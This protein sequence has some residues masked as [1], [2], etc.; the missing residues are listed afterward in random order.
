MTELA[1]VVGVSP[2]YLSKLFSGIGTPS[3]PLAQALAREMNLPLEQ[4][5]NELSELSAGRAHRN[6]KD[7]ND[8]K[9]GKNGKDG[10]SRNGRI[11]RITRIKK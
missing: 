7:S 10:N 4:L 2:S 1:G 6:A 3:V 8:G 5:L 11:T 9:D